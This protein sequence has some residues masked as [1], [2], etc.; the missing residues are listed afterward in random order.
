LG[1]VRLLT[2]LDRRYP[3]GF[4]WLDRRLD[5]IENGRAFA[6]VAVTPQAL[7]AV[8]IAT[9]KGARRVKLSTFLVHPAFRNCG[10]GSRLLTNLTVRWLR[11]DVE[12]AIVTVDR[13]DSA[14]ISFFKKH[15]FATIPDSDVRYGIDRWD[16]VLRWAPD[17]AE[18]S[19]SFA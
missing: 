10:L 12:R 8:A 11:C 2:S 17:A 1:V 5:D 15:D 14:T 3:G 6:D 18:C 4:A 16:H 13:T 7:A 9:P 19:T